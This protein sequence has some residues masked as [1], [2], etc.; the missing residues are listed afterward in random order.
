MYVYV[1][2]FSCS[3]RVLLEIKN[4][5]QE[6]G[7]CTCICFNCFIVVYPFRFMYQVFPGTPK[8]SQRLLREAAKIG[9][10]ETVEKLVSKFLF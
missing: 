5:K 4:S 3:L 6:A 8:Q 1:F 9:D 2:I 7:T 10:L